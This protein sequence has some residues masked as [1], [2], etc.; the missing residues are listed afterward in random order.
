MFINILLLGLFYFFIIFISHQ[1]IIFLKNKLTSPIIKEIIEEESEYNFNNDINFENT[2]NNFHYND[3]NN[4]INEN[5]F[6][7]SI[8]ENNFMNI[9]NKNENNNMNKIQN[10]NNIDEINIDKNNNINNITEIKSIN[11]INENINNNENLDINY[12]KDIISQSQMKE[13][14][15]NFFKEIRNNI[16]IK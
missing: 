2:S 3:K 7:N 10:I 5:N 6:I 4:D 8:N 15:N 11:N 14:L 1:I 9:I 12:E 16:N 13:E